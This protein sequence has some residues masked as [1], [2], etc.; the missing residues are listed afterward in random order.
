MISRLINLVFNKWKCLIRFCVIQY[1][2][3]FSFI[4]QTPCFVSKIQG[5]KLTNRQ[6]FHITTNSSYFIL[7][8]AVIWAVSILFL[9]STLLPYWSFKWLVWWIHLV[10]SSFSL[11]LHF[12]VKCKT[13]DFVG[14]FPEH[15]MHHFLVIVACR[16]INC[17]WSN[18]VFISFIKEMKSRLHHVV[19]LWF[20]QYWFTLTSF[21]FIIYQLRNPSLKKFNVVFLGVSYYTR[22]SFFNNLKFLNHLFL[23][24]NFFTLFDWFILWFNFRNFHTNIWSPFLII[25]RRQ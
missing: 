12:F 3:R 13:I 9:N 4:I 23:L 14:K 24:F 18:L 11:G 8:T 19:P 5:D 21:L 10:E 16:I 1:T 6:S 22:L 17:T 25:F 20:S 15:T 7:V 2:Q